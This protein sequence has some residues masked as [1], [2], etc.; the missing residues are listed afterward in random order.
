MGSLRFFREGKMWNASLPKSRKSPSNNYYML[1]ES[2]YDLQDYADWGC[3]GWFPGCPPDSSHRDDRIGAKVNPS[4]PPQKNKSL[5]LQKKKKKSVEQNLTPKKSH[6]RTIMALAPNKF[7]AQ[8]PSH[9]NQFH[10]NYAAEIRGNYQESSDC[11]EY[12]QKSLLKSSYP[13]KNTFQNIL[14]PQKIRK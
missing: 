4:P 3:Q 14:T 8:F 6:N 12:P 5:G 11:F 9:K 10:R 2:E 13:Q 1:N 7:R